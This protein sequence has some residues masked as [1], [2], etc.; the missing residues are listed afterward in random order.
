MR[1]WVDGGTD[2]SQRCPQQIRS[3]LLPAA[4]RR[5]FHYRAAQQLPNLGA[6]SGHKLG[7]S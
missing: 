5:L 2:A 6:E 1:T 7:G 4:H 3:G